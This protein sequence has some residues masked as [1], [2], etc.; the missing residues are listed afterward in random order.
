MTEKER[1]Q[2]QKLV[3]ISKNPVLWAKAFLRTVD[4]DTKKVGPWVARWYQAE[5]LMSTE[6]RRVARCGRRTGKTETM[7]VDSIWRCMTTRSYVCLYAAPYESQIRNIFNRITELIN[8]SPKVKEC[9]ISN[10]KTP[11]EIKFSNGSAIRGFTTGASSGGGAA[12]VRGQ[13]AD[14][15]LLDESDYM[16]DADFD[17]ILAIAGEREGIKIFLSST[18]TGA[19]K[20]FW[21]CCTDPKMH[22]KEFHFPSMCNPNWGPKMEEE[23][24]SMLSE[25]G[26]VHEVLADF[27]AQ[28]TGVFDKDKL[29]RAMQFERY[30]Y[31]PLTFSQKHMVETNNWNVDMMIPPTN[32]S[33][34]LGAYRPNRFRTVGVDWD[35]IYI[36]F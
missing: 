31:M 30:A 8:L 5:M 15:I 9:V 28:E 14:E 29:D 34:M 20:R 4:N 36:I 3:A 22:F 18:P 7:C 10:T 13:R 35:K 6:N 33:N 17:S 23:F 19:R 12:S 25:N 24:R 21:Q 26:Y 32:T 2:R 27:G 16:Q 11:F 1:L